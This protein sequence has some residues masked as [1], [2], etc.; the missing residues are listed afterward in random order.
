VPPP[1]TYKLISVFH[2]GPKIEKPGN[3]ANCF[4]GFYEHYEKLPSEILWFKE[5]VNS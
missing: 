5:K 4:A 1:K 3:N 2:D